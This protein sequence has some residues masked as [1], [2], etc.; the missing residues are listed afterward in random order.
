V[1]SWLQVEGIAPTW[2]CISTCGSILCDKYLRLNSLQPK[3]A[4][5]IDSKDISPRGEGAAESGKGS[6]LVMPVPEDLACGFFHPDDNIR[7]PNAL[8]FSISKP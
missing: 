5:I 3:S 7:A 2:S 6:E 1:G 8:L 4:Q